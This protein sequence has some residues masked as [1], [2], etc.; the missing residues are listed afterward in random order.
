MVSVSYRMS[1]PQK[2]VEKLKEN[3]IQLNRDTLKEMAELYIKIKTEV[4]PKELET[5][6]EFAVECIKRGIYDRAYKISRELI[7]PLRMEYVSTYDVLQKALDTFEYLRKI[8]MKDIADQIEKIKRFTDEVGEIIRESEAI[9]SVDPFIRDIILKAHPGFIFN[10]LFLDFFGEWIRNNPDKL[11]EIL[12]KVF[13]EGKRDD[14]DKI[15]KEIEN[16][17]DFSE[18]ITAK[19]NSESQQ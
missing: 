8:S 4:P 2:V 15:V 11:V 12:K 9:K 6:L 7:N 3:G 10:V 17:M 13:V 16:T 18:V 5:T 1:V 14:V 19:N